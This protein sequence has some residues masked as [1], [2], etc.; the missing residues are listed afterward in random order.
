MTF[1]EVNFSSEEDSP[2]DVADE[3]DYGKTVEPKTKGPLSL[4]E[5]QERLKQRK[6]A[7]RLKGQQKRQKSPIKI[8]DDA[9][10]DAYKQQLKA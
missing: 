8:V 2:A 4:R 1:H 5:I 6:R 7:E 3:L 9:D 10:R